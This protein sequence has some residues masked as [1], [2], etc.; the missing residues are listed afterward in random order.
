[1]KYEQLAKDIIDLVGGTENVNSVTHCVTRL[2]FR[3]KD[4]DKADK[5]ALEDHEDVVTVRES[6]G[7][8]QVVIGNHVPEVYKAVVTEGG[9]ENEKQEDN[10]DEKDEKKKGPLSSFIDIISNIFLP[11]LPLLMATGIIKGFNS[12]FV[13]LG[14]LENTSGTYQILNVIGDGFFTFLPIF[15]GYTA[16]KKF[17]GTPF[18]G[19]AIAAALVHPSLAAIGESEPFMTLFSGTV[20]E[21]PVQVSFL[22]IPIILMSYTASVVPIILSTYFAAKVERWFA[23]IIPQVVKSFIVPF[24]T[25]LIIVPL[26]FIIIGPIATWLAQSIGF[27]IQTGYEFVPLVAGII[28]G[29]FWQVLVIFGVHWGI[30]PIYYNN[31]AVQGYDMLIAMTFAASFAQIGAV[32]AVWIRTKNKKLKRLSLPAFVSGFFGVTEPAIYGITLPLKTPFIMS[33]IGSAA[34]GAIIAMTGAALYSAGPLGVF[35]I[36]TFI[37]PEN[38]I[39]GGFWGMMISIIVAFAVAFVLTYFFG[40]ISQKEN[41]EAVV[42]DGKMQEDVYD[43]ELVEGDVNNAD[44]ETTVQNENI[45]SPANGDIIPLSSIQ[46]EVFSSEAMGKGVAIHPNEGRMYAPANGLVTTLFKTKHAIGIKTDNGAEVLIHIGMDTVQLDGEFFE[47][48]IEQGDK[49]KAGDLLVEFDINKIEEAGYSVTTPIVITNT[50][51]YDRV[52]TVSDDTITKEDV[53]IITKV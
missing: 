29:G 13:A 32:L 6:S 15:L 7:Q 14:W 2:R 18:L 50:N 53:L 42:G 11:V 28:V 23:S 47:A 25:L 37:H 41:T 45:L 26:T 27:A 31:L 17:G 30:I 10:N 22:G 5:K 35:K 3:L 20:L 48:H 44:T 43:E 52:E 16:M 8:F 40:R 24:L 1:M 12:M 51:E 19:M 38:G 36:P 21:S 34:G 4:H 39:D 33:C 46:D 49:V 9:F